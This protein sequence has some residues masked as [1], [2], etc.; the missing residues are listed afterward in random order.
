SVGVAVGVRVLV[1]VAVAVAVGVRVAV[2]VGVGVLSALG[3]VYSSALVWAAGEKRLKLG[4]PPATST[5]PVL[6][7]V[8]V[9][10]SRGVFIP[11]VPL[12]SPVAGLY[13]SA[14]ASRL[15]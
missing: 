10:R 11:A 8:A 2:P 14:L 7:S 5:W 3:S 6:S 15:L 12:H 1:T 13:S 9:C 4:A